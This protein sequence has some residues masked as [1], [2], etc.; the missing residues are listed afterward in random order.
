MNI[1]L[2]YVERVKMMERILKISDVNFKTN[3]HYNQ[4][5]KIAEMYIQKQNEPYEIDKEHILFDT[6]S[7]VTNEEVWYVNV[8]SLKVKQKWPDAYETLAISEKKGSLSYVMNDH[9]VVVEKF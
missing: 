2:G 1:F 6:K 4:I 9:G 7:H 8:I 5:I 3:L